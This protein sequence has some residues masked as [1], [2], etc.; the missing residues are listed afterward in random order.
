MHFHLL[1]GR[2]SLPARQLRD[3]TMLLRSID[4][5]EA[6]MTSQRLA[7]IT[8]TSSWVLGRV[9]MGAEPQIIAL[10]VLVPKATF[11]ACRIE[12][13]AVSQGS[14]RQGIG[15]QLMHRL[16]DLAKVQ[17]FRHVEVSL[18]EEGSPMD[19]MLRRFNFERKSDRYTLTLE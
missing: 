2:D 19:R 18:A 6:E 15:T 3:M 16:L 12:K 14:H 9:F 11:D 13:V 10:G 8:R 17:A 7:D 4:P 1:D 5:T